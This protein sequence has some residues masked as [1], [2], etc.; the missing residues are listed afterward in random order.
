MLTISLVLYEN[1]ESQV[2]NIISSCL[3]CTKVSQIYVIDNSKNKAPI[4]KNQR[5]KVIQSKENIGFGKAHNIALRK[6]LGKSKYHLVLNPDISLE[7][8]ILD[9]IMTFMDSDPSLGLVMPKVLNTDGTIQ[10]NCKLIPTPLNLIIRRFLYFIPA[11]LNWNNYK[12]EMK[13]S[14][15]NKIQEVPILS[16]CFMFFKVDA[17]KDVGLFD[18][19]YFLYVE[20]VD[21]CRRVH[22]KYKTMY[23]PYVSIYHEHT[24]GS[25]KNRKLMW[26]NSISAI[27]YFNKWGWF[28]DNNRS[29]VNKKIIEKTRDLKPIIQNVKSH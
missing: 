14:D 17:L 3:E 28:N 4:R 11:L 2:N 19:R 6:I 8:S 5:V 10:Y 29:A 24:K 26:Q 1:N 13:F 16:G 21:L 23:Y 9:E 18:Q 20:D 27:K 7:S 15:Y 22:E 25:Y 12:Y